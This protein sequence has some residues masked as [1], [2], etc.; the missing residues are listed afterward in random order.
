VPE[1]KEFIKLK[2]AFDYA[3][4]VQRKTAYTIILKAF[5]SK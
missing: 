3:T 4:I 1:I 2:T 5:F